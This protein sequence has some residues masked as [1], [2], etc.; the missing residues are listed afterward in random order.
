VDQLIKPIDLSNEF[1][2]YKEAEKNFD[3]FAPSAKRFILRWIKLSKTTPTRKKR[4][5]SV[6]KL[7]SENKKIPGV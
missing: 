3:A 5:E 6:A 1:K 7:A 4:I 2:K